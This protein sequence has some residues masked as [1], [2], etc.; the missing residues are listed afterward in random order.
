MAHWAQ[1]RVLRVLEFGDRGVG[2]RVVAFGFEMLGFRLWGL[3][4]CA[5]G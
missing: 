1:L 5:R 2:F 4:L 3:G